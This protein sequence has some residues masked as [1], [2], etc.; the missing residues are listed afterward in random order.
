MQKDNKS[1]ATYYVLHQNPPHI[2]Y[3]A[4]GMTYIVMLSGQTSFKLSNGMEVPCPGCPCPQALPIANLLYFLHRNRIWIPFALGI[5]ALIVLIHFALMITDGGEMAAAFITSFSFWMNLSLLVLGALSLIA[6]GMAHFKKG[7]KLEWGEKQEQA[8]LEPGTIDILPNIL[9]MSESEDE[10]PDQYRK[11][12]DTAMSLSGK[13]W[14]V[15]IPFRQNF[16]VVIQS[17]YLDDDLS[18]KVFLR[19]APIH[20]GGGVVTHEHAKACANTYKAETWAQYVGYCREFASRFKPWAEVERITS[21]KSNPI[22]SLLTNMAATIL[23]VA[24]CVAPSFAQKSKQVADYLGTYRY[25]KDV[26]EAGKE[27]SFIFKKRVLSREADGKKTYAELLPAS[28]YYTNE[29]DAGHLIGITV[30]GE[31]IAPVIQ[32]NEKQKDHEGKLTTLPAVSKGSMFDELPDSSALQMMKQEHLLNSMREW[33]KLE[34]TLDYVMWRFWRLMMLA[35]GIGGVLWILAKVSAKDS[36]KDVYS[37]AFIG[38]A[39]T[40]LHIAAKT[41]LFVLMCLPTFVIVINDAI[42]AYYTETFSWLWVIK[43]GI[44]YWVWQYVME[45]LLPDSPGI[46]TSGSGNYPVNQKN[47]IG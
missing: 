21:P 1:A 16:G 46:R 8:L 45:R 44:I 18:G 40:S 15:M 34:P 7:I 14:V 32:R 47:L 33:R 38:N 30:G 26:P 11:R 12:V 22:E 27:V 19:S 35:F 2:I 41:G 3:E 42:R 37:V 13:P 43:Y 31:T 9:V 10:T 6:L 5:A 39:I 20:D 4:G 23:L 17:N 29:S 24:F 28:S 36:L 25:E